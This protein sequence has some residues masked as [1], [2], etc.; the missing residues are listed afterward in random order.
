M[1]SNNDSNASFGVFVKNSSALVLAVISFISSV[2]GFVKLF[3]DKDAGLIT[4]ISLI[5]G[6][7]LLLSICLYY[8]RFWKPEKHDKARSA[9]EPSLSDEQVKAHSQK[10]RLRRLVRRLAFAGLILL[11]ILSISGFASWQYFQSLPS[12]DIIVLVADFEGPDLKNYR[13]TKNIYDRLSNA[14][15]KYSDV[16]IQRLNQ[17]VSESEI[18][19]SEGEKHKATIVIW[20]DYGVTDVA[21]QISTRF[22]VMH[23]SKDLPELGKQANGMPQESAIAELKSFKLQTRLSQE[24][25]YLSLFTLGITRYTVADWDGAIARFSDAL[26]QITETT[27]I[28]DRSLVDFYRGTAYLQKGDYDRALADFNQTIKLQPNFVQAYANRG[29]IYLTKSDNDRALAD[30]NQTLKLQPNFV[31]AYNNRGLIYYTKGNYD[32]AI[33]DFTQALKLKLDS[34]VPQLNRPK[35]KVMQPTIPNNKG[36]WLLRWF[37]GKALK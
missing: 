5:V 28:L 34:D 11:P 24:L 8:A 16:R 25:S 14:T 35:F 3:A 9:F 33:A 6:I 1:S 13:V 37:Y 15:K 4:L 31:P 29:L 19:R 26:N 2:Y 7:L 22:E 23:P 27:S 10:E 17:V 32:L 36:F 12:K 18:A 20:G 21:V 30:L